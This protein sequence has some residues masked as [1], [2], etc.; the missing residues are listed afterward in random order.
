ME[1]LLP[2]VIKRDS[3][4]VDFDKEKIKN[5]IIGANNE[6]DEVY[7]IWC[8]DIDDIVNKVIEDIKYEY[9]EKISVEDIST[10]TETRLMIEGYYEVARKF[11]KYRYSRA[12][13]REFKKRDDE[14]FSLVSGE[15]EELNKEN[16]NKDTRLL[17]TMRDYMAGIVS[18]DIA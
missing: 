15:N 14:V 3:S 7:K 1:K 2:K 5:A 17:S 18:K 6:V 12:L 10:I 16:S 8:G 4:I 13:S 11:I 9:N